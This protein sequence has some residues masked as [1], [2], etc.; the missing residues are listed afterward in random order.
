MPGFDGDTLYGGNVNFS[1][2]NAIGGKASITLNGQMLIG[3]T[4]PN[5]GGTTINVGTVV[6][7]L[8]T[9]QI[10]YQSPNIT[11][12]V[13]GGFGG[14]IKTLSDDVNTPVSPTGTGNIQLVGH[15]VEQGSTKFSTV[16][17]GANLINLNPMSSFRWIVD[18]LGFNGTHTTITSAMASATSGDTIGI[19]A[20][21]TSF[22]ENFTIN[23]GVNITAMG[24]DSFNGNVTINGTIT[25]TGAGTSVITGCRLQTNSLNALVVSGSAASVLILKDCYLNCTNTTGLVYSSSSGSS[26]VDFIDCQGDIGTTGI[27]LWTSSGA[28]QISTKNCLF[29]NS[30]ASTTVTTASAGSMQLGV[31]HFTSPLSTTGTAN[32]G[33][34]YL[35]VDTSA[36]NTAAVTTAGTGATTLFVDCR[37]LSGSAA[38]MSVG[39][40][41]TVALSNNSYNSTNSN[42]ITGAGTINTS[43]PLFANT[44]VGVNVTTITDYNFGRI[45]TFT[46]G[47]SFG[48]SSTGVTYTTQTGHYTR[49]GNLVFFY[50]FISL[51]SKGSQT[52]TVSVTGLPFTS[53][54]TY[55]NDNSFYGDLITYPA[56]TYLLGEIEPGGTTMDIVNS[57]SNIS[58]QNL[59]N[60]AIA[61][62]S[63]FNCTGWYFTS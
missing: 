33:A 62:T 37:F 57:G 47:I 39:S 42:P 59:A 24:A 31:S 10:G 4:T 45:G 11:L 14:F 5:A 13:A 63:T 32:I 44:G 21:S 9:L 12:D 20:S 54:A 3:T 19:V 50:L 35:T 1:T 22:T 48:G 2:K 43:P 51:S 38:C 30:G 23:P 36:I 60:T 52:G 49:I 28:G 25:M 26:A 58:H 56:G 53:S 34:E 7:P 6:S 40:G 55:Y 18:K 41:T 29:T 27:A 8:G 46:P 61:N 16:V 15:V 17:S